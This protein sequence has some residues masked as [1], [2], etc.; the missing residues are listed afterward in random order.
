MSAQ[1]AICTLR[2]P[3][4]TAL[5]AFWAHCPAEPPTTAIS[6]AGQGREDMDHTRS[7]LSSVSQPQHLT[8]LQSPRLRTHMTCPS[9]RAGVRAGSGH[10]S[11]PALAAHT[12]TYQG[13]KPR[14]VPWVADFAQLVALSGKGRE[15]ACPDCKRELTQH[16]RTGLASR[17]QP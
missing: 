2:P 3:S 10:R 15:E 6:E 5:W 1:P 4:Y 11:F 13:G 12:G 7:P 9:L 8:Q 17:K 14:G 16:G